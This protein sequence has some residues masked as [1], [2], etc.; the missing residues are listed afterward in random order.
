MRKV[1]GCLKK[2]VEEFN[3]ISE[4]D[5]I[6]IGLSGG[7]DSMALLYALKLYQNFSPVNYTLKAVTLT[8]GFEH[9]NISPISEF[10]S[11]LNIEHIVSETQIGKIVF[12]ERKAAHP[13]GICSRMR[14]GRLHKLCA[15]H[16]I[17]KLA[18]GHH[19]DD[20]VETLL[21]SMLYES[22]I[23]SFKPVTYLSR[24]RLTQIRPLIYA[25]ESDI[26]E[27]VLR[28][29]IPVA[30]NPCPAARHTKRE[31][32]KNLLRII[33]EDIPDAKKHILAALGNKEQLEIFK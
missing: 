25:F 20:A 6:G 13:C 5:T 18:L 9:F 24:S 14:R 21:L 16:R 30:E 33:S 17:D 28:H 32:V 27:A 10:C 26:A 12:E 2:A 29:N 4:G 7:K 3:M 1:L 11:S 8:M 23:H 15:E 31:Y 19:A 22:R